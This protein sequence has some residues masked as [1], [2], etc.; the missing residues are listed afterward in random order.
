MDPAAGVAGLTSFIFGLATTLY[1]YT[2]EASKASRSA[3]E[4]YQ[5]LVTL[6][7]VLDRLSQF[8]RTIPTEASITFDKT[9]VLFQALDGCRAIVNSLEN[10]LKKVFDGRYLPGVN[11]HRFKWPLDKEHH[12]AI[13]GTLR[14]YQALFEFSLTIDNWWVCDHHY[15]RFELDAVEEASDKLSR[16]LSKVS[17]DVNRILQNQ[18]ESFKI[19]QQHSKAIE[20][21][22]S[23]PSLQLE[24]DKASAERQAILNTILSFDHSFANLSDI[25]REI[26]HITQ[27]VDRKFVQ[28]NFS[29][30]YHLQFGV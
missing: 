15:S 16:L 26:A 25:S 28:Y 2:R 19:I 27:V 12:Q 10:D 4:L 13:I 6:Q 18:L 22:P 1:N 5:Q 17:S 3:Q 14:G 29:R 20:M 7:Q 23:A 8:L 21:L 9:S 30:L 11:V 24:I